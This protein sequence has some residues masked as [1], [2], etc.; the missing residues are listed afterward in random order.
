MDDCETCG[1]EGVIEVMGDGDN[2]EWDVIGYKPCP[3]CEYDDTHVLTA[4]D[5]L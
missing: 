1:G 2:F 3:D 5:L 4:K